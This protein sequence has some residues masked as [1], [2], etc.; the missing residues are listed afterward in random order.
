[1]TDI[2]GKQDDGGWISATSTQ[3]KYDFTQ[4]SEVAYGDVDRNCRGDYTPPSKEAL[5]QLHKG[6]ESAKSGTVVDRGSFAQYAENDRRVPRFELNNVSL[7]QLYSGCGK[8]PYTKTDDLDVKSANTSTLT[9]EKVRE[10]LRLPPVPTTTPN[11]SNSPKS[12]D[13]SH[14]VP[15]TLC[16]S[17]AIIAIALV[18]AQGHKKPGRTIYNW[19]TQPISFCSYMDAVQRHLLKSLDGE[20]F[21]DELSELAGVPIRHDWAAMSGLA[22]IEDARQAGTLVDDRPVKGGAAKFLK[23]VTK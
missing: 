9:P 23:E 10:L 15:L 2:I 5:E 4:T 22:I 14:K 20:D 6:I 19:R 16:P 1:M 8:V 12:L 18:I 13:S 3:E 11:T 7:D 21:D 17:S